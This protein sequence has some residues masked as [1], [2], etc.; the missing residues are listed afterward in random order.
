LPELWLQ[1]K[2][3]FIDLVKYGFPTIAIIL[4]ILSFIGSRR[5]KKVQDRLSNLEEKIKNYE[6]EK[7]EQERK[8]AS[9]SCVEARIINISKNNYSMKIW[10]SGKATAYNVDFQ[11]PEECNGMIWKEKVPFEFLESGKN[12]DERVLVFGS[13]PDKFKIITIWTDE[14]GTPYSKEQMVSL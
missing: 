12:F 2:E 1:F 3:S 7:I 14:N 10:N 4:S 11:V 8:E 5:T 6:L 13:S 9:L